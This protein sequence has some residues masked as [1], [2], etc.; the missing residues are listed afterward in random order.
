[1]NAE[2]VNVKATTEEGLGVYRRWHRHGGPRRG[3]AGK[4]GIEGRLRRPFFR[5]FS[6]AVHKLDRKEECLWS[7]I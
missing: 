6:A 3:A 5:T 1:M 2:Q 4:T 7:T